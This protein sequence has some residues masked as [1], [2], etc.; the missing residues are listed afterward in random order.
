MFFIISKIL[1]IFLSPI[2][3]IFALVLISLFSKKRRKSRK[4]LLAAIILF[5]IFSN[6]FIV[7]EV[8]RVWEVPVTKTEELDDC[9]DVGIVLG[10]SMVTYDSKN[11]RLTYRNNI[12]RIL[13]AIELYKIG[14]I[15][16]ILISGGAGNIVFRDMLES[17]FIKRFLINIG[18]TENDIIID[19]I[20]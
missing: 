6:S 10:G 9:Y 19:S 13:Q 17:V 18:I 20:S 8:M 15:Q 7:D 2:L 3:W 14:K 5:L 12:D 1:S 4:Y 16:K 11:D